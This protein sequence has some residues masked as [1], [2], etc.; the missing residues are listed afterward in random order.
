MHDR[1]R[2]AAVAS[3]KVGVVYRNANCPLAGVT[4]AALIVRAAARSSVV[5]VLSD[6]SS[7]ALLHRVAIMKWNAGMVTC[8]YNQKTTLL[9]SA[10]HMLLG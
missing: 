3:D 4:S 1:H 5:F 7:L 9:Q 2:E 6:A 8:P 10:T